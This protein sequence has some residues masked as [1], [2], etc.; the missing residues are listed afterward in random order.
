MKRQKSHIL[1]YMRVCGYQTEEKTD[2]P[3]L[4]LQINQ[5]GKVV[6]GQHF[7]CYVQQLRGSEVFNPFEHFFFFLVSLVVQE[8]FS[9][10]EGVVFKIISGYAYLPDDLF[11]GGMELEAGQGFV[12]DFLELL[13]DQ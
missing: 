12:A 1:E 13:V 10:I 9:H 4:N 11:L 2:Y 7:V 6:L 5:G 8:A 3:V